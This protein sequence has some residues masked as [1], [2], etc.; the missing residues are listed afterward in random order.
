MASRIRF[1][2]G[3]R[4]GGKGTVLLLR[5]A[6]APIRGPWQLRAIISRR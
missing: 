2:V 1:V 5:P 4:V 6:P 3:R